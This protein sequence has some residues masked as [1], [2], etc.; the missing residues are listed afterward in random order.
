VFVIYSLAMDESATPTAALR[1]RLGD[2]INIATRSVHAR[3]NK[4]LILRLP[5][6]LPPHVHNPSTY[7]SGLVHIAPIYLVFESLWRNIVLSDGTVTTAQTD[8][9][10]LDSPKLSLFP[11]DHGHT[12]SYNKPIPPVCPPHV[13]SILRSLLL[14]PLF[15]SPALHRD[16]QYITGWTPAEVSSQIRLAAQNGRLATFLAHTRRSVSE[17]P[18]VLLAYAWVLYM[19]L[20]SGGRLIRASLEEPG[21]AFWDRTADPVAPSCRACEEPVFDGDGLPLSFFRFA[22]PEDGEDLKVEFKKLLAEAE[23]QLS[24]AEISDVVQEAVCIFDNMILLV[25]QLDEVCA[26]SANSKG[27]ASPSQAEEWWAISL[28]P[29]LLWKRVRDSFAMAKDKGLRPPSGVE[30]KDPKGDDVLDLRKGKCPG[31]TE[32]SAW[33]VTGPDAL[34]VMSAS[35]EIVEKEHLEEDVAEP[36]PSP[37]LKSV[38]FEGDSVASKVADMDGSS[39]MGYLV[40]PVR[41]VWSAA[42]LFGVVGVAWGIG[43][44]GW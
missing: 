44:I 7:V 14:P 40:Q 28:V 6:A 25:A 27:S 8:T 13:R 5:L 16:I 15:R 2:K 3:L 30:R 19:A 31:R 4:T 36:E 34:G 42:V 32:E 10:L 37:L 11:F 12:D 33:E 18:H 9:Q 22:T 26:E 43:R 29:K 17:N 1:P 39:D 24:D 20:F 35:M 41:P 38:H 21:H 23:A